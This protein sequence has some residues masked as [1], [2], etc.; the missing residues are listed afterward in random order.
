MKET[1]TL[2]SLGLV[3][4]YEA[5]SSWWQHVPFAHALIELVKPEL[6]VELGSHYGVSFFSFCEAAEKYSSQTYVYAIDTW[7]GDIQAGFYSEKV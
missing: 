4:N 6:V 5:P 3:P 7:E 1:M 2:E